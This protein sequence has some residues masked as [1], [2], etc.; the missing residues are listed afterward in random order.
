MK[1]KNL[2]IRNETN[3]LK[4]ISQISVFFLFL[5]KKSSGQSIEKISIAFEKAEKEKN[6]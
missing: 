1:H 6:L 5:L 3:L 2:S 4:F